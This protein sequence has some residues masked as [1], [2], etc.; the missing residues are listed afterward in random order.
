MTKYPEAD[1]VVQVHK[2]LNDI[3]IFAGCTRPGVGES[4]EWT[5]NVNSARENRAN[6][7]KSLDR[8]IL[9]SALY[10]MYTGTLIE[11]KAVSAEA[12]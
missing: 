3:E 4:S 9:F 8:E 1:A 12:K 5:S 2:I 6:F 11:M 10:G 7:C